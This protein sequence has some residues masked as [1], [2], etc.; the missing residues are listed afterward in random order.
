VLLDRKLHKEVR[1]KIKK[2]RAKSFVL[3]HP[4]L[5]GIPTLGI[6]PAI[7]KDNAVRS[8]SRSMLRSHKGLRKEYGRSKDRRH[9]RRI[10][11]EK[12]SIERAR[13]EAPV[14]AIGAAAAGMSPAAMKYLA[15]RKAEA[16]KA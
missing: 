9:K 3:R 6:A 15:I 5:T 14:R 4:I 16:D 8:I 1:D 11:E 2:R 10:E 7:A 12:L 13:A